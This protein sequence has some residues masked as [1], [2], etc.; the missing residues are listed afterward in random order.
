VACRYGIRGP[1]G[2]YGV[3]VRRTGIRPVL[4]PPFL[5]DVRISGSIPTTLY[6]GPA[7]PGAAAGVC[8]RYIIKSYLLLA[9]VVWIWKTEVRIPVSGEILLCPG[10]IIYFKIQPIKSGTVVHLLEIII[11]IIA[12]S[13]VLFII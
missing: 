9:A 7:H 12:N 10:S 1:A 8:G 6:P 11:L 2:G 3:K 4:V 13:I 5:F